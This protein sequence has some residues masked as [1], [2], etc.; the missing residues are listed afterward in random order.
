MTMHRRILVS[1][2][3]LMAM[4][5]LAGTGCSDVCDAYCDA[6]VDKI[7]ELGCWEVWGTGWSDQ[8]YEDDADYLGHCKDTFQA[9]YQ[10][11]RENSDSAAA[12][13]RQTCSDKLD[14]TNAAESCDDVALA[15]Y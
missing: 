4:L 13:V 6:T 14:E 11:A 10:D 2:F 9:T 7:G 12:D 5:A 15:G 1:S 8:G 3:A